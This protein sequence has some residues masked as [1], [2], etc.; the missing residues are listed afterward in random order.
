MKECPNCDQKTISLKWILFGKANGQKGRCFIC[1]NCGERIKKIRALGFL[2][3]ILYTEIGFIV[4]LGLIGGFKILFDSLF[5]SFTFALV[6]IVLLQVLINVLV[7]LK[8]TDEP[9]CQED[10]SKIEAFFGL[11]IMFAI[12]TMMVNFFIVQPLFR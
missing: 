8:V 5:T 10:M 6:T 9:Y 4:L 7:V 11:I 3:P 12:I 2:E 1:D